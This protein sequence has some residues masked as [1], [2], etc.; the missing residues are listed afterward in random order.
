MNYRARIV[1]NNKKRDAPVP[2]SLVL[3]NPLF[4]YVDWQGVLRCGRDELGTFLMSPSEDVV[5]EI[6]QSPQ[7]NLASCL[8]KLI[9][10][11]SLAFGVV[12]S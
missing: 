1:I 11:I 5:K 9:Q 10:I 3:R 8:A 6:P 12:G 2:E 4:G 7:K